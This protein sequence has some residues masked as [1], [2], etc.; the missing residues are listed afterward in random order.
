M[1]VAAS[2]IPGLEDIVKGGDPRRL[3][4]A[5]RKVA[6]LFLNGA[7]TRRFPACQACRR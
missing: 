5:S 2:L 3:S 4:E 6:D 7:A 1:T